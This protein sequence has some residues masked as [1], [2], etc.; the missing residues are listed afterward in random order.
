MF[1]RLP[2]RATFVADTNFVS[3][4]QK[5]V[6][7]YAQKHF[8]SATDVSQFA[9]PKKHY[10]Q[11]CVPNNVSSFTRAL[12][13]LRPISQTWLQQWNHGNGSSH[14]SVYIDYMHIYLRK[15]S[16]LSL[17]LRLVTL[18][19]SKTNYDHKTAL[20]KLKPVVMR[21]GR[22]ELFGRE[23]QG[24]LISEAGMHGEAQLYPWGVSISGMRYKL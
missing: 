3:G 20:V 21:S 5:N 2:E 12:R 7:D 10:G 18:L 17:A 15:L 23:G 19:N 16:P 6:S 24:R 11:Q 8:V 14:T 1:P 9:Q 4:T 13:A 22:W